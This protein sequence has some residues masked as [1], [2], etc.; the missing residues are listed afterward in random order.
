MHTTEESR[1]DWEITQT[2]EHADYSMCTENYQPQGE[3]I[4]PSGEG[5]AIDGSTSNREVLRTGERSLSS[6]SSKF[7]T[8]ENQL[9]GRPWS[10]GLFDCHENQTN[11][12]IFNH[13]FAKCTG[14]IY[15][16]L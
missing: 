6:A 11:S 9:I 4:L 10:T 15:W 14:H 16:L 5:E 3:E 7:Q 12:N 2:G 13:V 8:D 1:E